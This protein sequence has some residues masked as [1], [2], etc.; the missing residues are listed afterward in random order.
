MSF[1]SVYLTGNQPF[2]LTQ[3]VDRP[4]DLIA[5]RGDVTTTQQH[6]NKT[7]IRRAQS[8]VNGSTMAVINFDSE[9]IVP[10][11]GSADLSG[12]GSPESG[13]LMN[14]FFSS[15]E[16]SHTLTFVDAITDGPTPFEWIP[17]S[18]TSR[19][20]RSISSLSVPKR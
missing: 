9:G 13:F 6:A 4:L 16:T 11:A 2:T 1:S 14:N 17:V 19:I 7:V 20:A 8:Q 3:L 12:V 15:L 18:T 5:S 10:A